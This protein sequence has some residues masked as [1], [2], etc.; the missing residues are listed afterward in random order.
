MRGPVLLAARIGGYSLCGS[1]AR[2]ELLLDSLMNNFLHIDFETRSRADIKKV[3]LDNYARQ[4]EILILAY[5]FGDGMVQTWLPSSGPIPGALHSALADPSHT[6]LAWNMAF[7]RAILEYCLRIKTDASGWIDP[8]AMARY[9]G[10]PSHLAECSSILSLGGMGKLSDG[11]RLIRKF[12]VPT[13]KG[14]FLPL[15]GP[16]WELFIEYC[17]RDVVAE[18][19]LYYRLRHLFS[20]P[21]HERD[22]SVFDSTVNAR[23]I[24]VDATFV[25]RATEAAITERISLA[26]KIEAL[27]GLDNPNSPSQ[28]LGWL[29]SKGY[30]YANL[31]AATVRTALG[32]HLPSEVQE[33]LRLRQGLAKSS[34]AKLE[35][36]S[37]LV[38]PDGRLRHNYKYYGAHTG[39]WSAGGNGHASVQLQNLPRG[40]V[41]DYDAAVSDIL[42]GNDLS[43]HGSP[44]SVISSCLRAA[45]RAPAGQQFTVSDL[46]QIEVRVLAWLANC[47]SM[48]DTFRRDGSDIYC[49]FAAARYGKTAA[50]VT[51][52]ERQIAKP[53]VLG[54]G[55]QLSGGDEKMIKGEKVK[56]GLWGYADKMGIQMTRREAHDAVA[57]FRAA[58]PEVKQLW[59]ALDDA[60][61]KAVNCPGLL[62]ECGKVKFGAVGDKLLFI[63]LPSGRRLHYPRPR[64]EPSFSGDKLTYEGKHL[65]KWCRKKLYGGAITENIVQAL[66]RDV[67]AEAMLRAEVAGFDTVGHT[68]D[69]II[70][71][72]EQKLHGNLTKLNDIMKEQPAWAPDLPL[73]CNGYE[74]EVY[75][76]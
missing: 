9:A 22:I 32:L 27:T 52:A 12:C 8:S 46:S 29:Q 76:K 40:N 71:L 7:E 31:A 39:R 25:S 28:L 49:D 4:A 19:E 64:I 1:I 10:L 18:R 6:K 66:A 59:Y 37:R 42:A 51:K 74:S 15:E 63:D 43:V 55:Y 26:T 13:K 23:G 53:A 60:A 68:H 34:V 17:R 54:C 57:D 69:E 21:A 48:L 41:K 14:N 61:K 62:R 44:L 58:Y 36:L 50:E 33:A 30:P 35:A 16:D 38:S 73:A 65:G 67:L 5:A 3:G 2:V 45:F 72:T 24:P 47:Q 75:R 56:T 20:L 70:T 11:K